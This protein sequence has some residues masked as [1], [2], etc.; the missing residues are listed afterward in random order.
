MKS[1]GSRSLDADDRRRFL[2]ADANAEMV[3]QIE[4]YPR[5][6]DRAVFLGAP[7]D[8]PNDPL[9]ADLPRAR[10]WA[11][12]NLTFSGPADQDG[13]TRTADLLAELL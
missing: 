6:R 5:I 11:Q 7:T 9:G 13:V 8:L 12:D 1:A 3:E 2:M 10:D 4:R